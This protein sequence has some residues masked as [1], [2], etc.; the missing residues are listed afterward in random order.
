[1]SALEFSLS[2]AN[3]MADAAAT[4]AAAAAT[5]LDLQIRQMG[6]ASYI[7]FSLSLWSRFLLLSLRSPF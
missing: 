5:K 7:T 1:V 6:A 2:A 4:A 3:E